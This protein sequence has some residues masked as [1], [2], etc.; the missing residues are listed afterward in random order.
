MS[1]A[2]VVKSG[3]QIFIPTYSGEEMQIGGSAVLEGVMMRGEKHWVVSVRQ[4]DKKIVTQ[5][6][7][8]NS[9]LDPY[10]IFRFPIFRGIKVLVDTLILSYQA[11]SFSAEVVG[12]E[13]ITISKRDMFFSFLIAFLL[14]TFLF[15]VL[16]TSILR[17]GENYFGFLK[18]VF[19]LNLI[20]GLLRVGLF[21]IYLGGIS[22]IEDIRRV[23]E[24]H[25]AEHM[26]I[27]TH[28]AGDELTPESAS[29]HSPLHLGCGTS[30]ILIVLFLMI[31]V[32]SFLGR[33]SLF[34][35]IFLRIVLL[36][37]LAGISYE[38]IK[39]SRKYERSFIVKA[40]T[41]PGLMLQKVTTRKPSKDQLEVAIHSLKQLL[42]LELK[43]SLGEGN[44]QLGKA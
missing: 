3:S 13:G 39:I 23:F 1:A 19:I 14:I 22:L 7:Q 28:E 17:F 27:H 9:F 5:E 24:Y 40:I 33:P 4:S 36:P 43:S 10:S 42:A 6:K 21:L 18:N 25:G 31:F 37:L 8:I 30:F 44:A 41:F 16:P 20:E 29:R 38:V 2:K 34:Y 12:G 26:V 15:I 11:L 32:F 35:R